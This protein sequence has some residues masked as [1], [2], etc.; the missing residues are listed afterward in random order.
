MIHSNVTNALWPEVTSWQVLGDFTDSDHRY[1]AYEVRLGRRSLPT[2]AVSPLGWSV[3]R[4][5]YRAMTAYIRSTPHVANNLSSVDPEN[6]ATQLEAYL[7][8]ICEAGM[9][10]RT[11]VRRRR[12]VHWWSPDIATLRAVCVAAQRTYQRADRRAS[13]TNRETKRRV[14]V[15]ARK[16]LRAAIKKAQRKAWATLCD[17]VE[18]GPWGLP[19]R[20]VAKGL[21]KADP[22]A[23]ARG[24]ETEL[25]DHLFPMAPRTIWPELGPDGVPV[26]LFT[27]EELEVVSSRLPPGKAPGPHGVPNEVVALLYRTNP[28]ALLHDYNCLVARVFPS[29]WKVARLVF[30]YKRAGK[31]VSSPSSFRPLCMLDAAGKAYERLVL[32]RLNGHLERTGGLAP[33]QYGFRSGMDT[34]DAIAAVMQKADLAAAGPVRDRHL[35]ALVTLDV[36]NAFN[37]AHWHLIDA[38]L[39]RRATPVYLREIVRSYFTER[40]LVVNKEVPA[41]QRPMTRRVPQG[42]VLGLTL[43]NVFYDDLLRVALP[44]GASLVGFA[45]DVAVVAI[46]RT[47]PLLEA[48]MNGALA[49]VFRWLADNGLNLAENKS[50]AVVL[51]RKWAYDSSSFRVNN[52][53]VAVSK[54]TRYLGVTL[55]TRRTFTQYA[56][57]AADTPSALSVAITKLMPNAGGPSNAKRRLLSVEAPLRGGDLGSTRDLL[58]A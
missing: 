23:A 53:V 56:R 9:P 18:R 15:S 5:D 13:H 1:I 45:D 41:A 33:N 14:F 34:S 21:D 51:S 8:E 26:P 7:S 42:S 40:I 19:Y 39:A 3:K 11:L 10:R 27:L 28:S 54:F 22:T 30:L 32:H 4:A 44:L 2:L 52:H 57:K 12:A 16:T 55:D 50:E 58:G 20:I 6:A 49:T 38:A 25:A 43:W 35:C 47:T 24:R 17:R 37:S 31:P 36:R 29:V 48:V 46:A